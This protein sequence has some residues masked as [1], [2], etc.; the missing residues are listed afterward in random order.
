MALAAAH[1]A[2]PVRRDDLWGMRAAFATNASIG[3]RPISS[4]DDREFDVGD[5]VI[6]QLRAA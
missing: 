6:A 1:V 5:P 2:R 4:V 3:V